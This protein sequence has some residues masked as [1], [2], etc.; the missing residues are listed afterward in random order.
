[1][2][3][4]FNAVKYCIRKNDKYGLIHFANMVDRW[5]SSINNINLYSGDNTINQIKITNIKR[6]KTNLQDL[7]KRIDKIMP[8][9][10]VKINQNHTGDVDK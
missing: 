3:E 6:T 10:V 1:M 4:I 8:V 9:K 5:Q 7:K 2:D